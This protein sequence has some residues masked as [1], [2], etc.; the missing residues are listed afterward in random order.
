MRL[1]AIA[2]LL[3]HASAEA[4]FADTPALT[5]IWQ[6]TSS[7]NTDQLINVL[8]QDH[9][10]ALQRASDGRGGLFWAYEFTNVDALALLKHLGAD[11]EGEDLD[12]HLAS[13][14]FPD[15]D[16][17]R[18]EFEADA[19]D[20]V[21]ELAALLAQKDEEFASF[22]QPMDAYDDLDEVDDESGGAS[23]GGGGGGNVDEID[24]AD[25]EDDEKDEV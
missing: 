11:E 20:K 7:G 19:A 14:F 24:Y 6:A 5:S 4:E 22:Q 23:T 2:A 13:H 9:S 3:V 18:A 16:A 1:L 21:E 17:A 12:G 15:G 25:D 8:V 10:F